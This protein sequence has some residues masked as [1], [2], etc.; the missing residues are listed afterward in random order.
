MWSTL[1]PVASKTASTNLSL[2]VLV[3]MA[4]RL[5]YYS[6]EKQKAIIT[7][8]N[9]IIYTRAYFLLLCPA[10]RSMHFTFIVLNASRTQRNLFGTRS[11]IGRS[12]RTSAARV[13]AIVDMVCLPVSAVF[14]VTIRPVIK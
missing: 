8:T 6:F 11:A 1:Y 4:L 13:G 12:S 10:M 14:G 3:N 7:A 9:R 5:F 2:F